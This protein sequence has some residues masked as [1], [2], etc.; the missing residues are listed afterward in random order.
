MIDYAEVGR[1]KSE[2]GKGALLKKNPI[3][4]LLFQY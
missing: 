1:E 2:V 3:S 4:S